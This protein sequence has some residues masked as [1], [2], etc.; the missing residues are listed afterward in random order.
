VTLSIVVDCLQSIVHVLFADCHNT[1]VYITG[2]E[3]YHHVPDMTDTTPF[4]RQLKI[5]SK[6]VPGLFRLFIPTFAFLHSFIK[7]WSFLFQCFTMNY[8]L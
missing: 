6:G 1:I 7:R 2:R 5:V 3:T 4:N 8:E